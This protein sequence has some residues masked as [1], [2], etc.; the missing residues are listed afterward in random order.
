MKESLGIISG[1]GGGRGPGS[2]GKICHCHSLIATP[3]NSTRIIL[4]WNQ[5]PVLPLKSSFGT[6]CHHFP[7]HGIKAVDKSVWKS[8]QDN[9]HQNVQQRFKY[10]VSVHYG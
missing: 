7:V 9:Q 6:I 1:P 4:I 2:P 3:V 8:E 10:V 5:S